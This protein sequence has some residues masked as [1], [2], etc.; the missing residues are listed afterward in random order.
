MYY[1]HAQAR[2]IPHALSLTRKQKPS[3]VVSV[4]VQRQRRATN[5]TVRTH[6]LSVVRACMRACAHTYSFMMCLSL[7]THAMHIYIRTLMGHHLIEEF[8]YSIYLY[9]EE[10]QEKTHTPCTIKPPQL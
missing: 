9:I 7:A 10:P 1:T 2:T 6:V 8:R 5:G 4:R 3:F